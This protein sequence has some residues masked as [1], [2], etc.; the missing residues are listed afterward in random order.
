M[1]RERSYAVCLK[2]DNIP[3]GYVTVGEADSFDLGY[4][5]KKE[6]RRR[7]IMTEAARAVLEELERNGVPYVTATHDVK[8]PK[9][10][11]V[12]KRLGMKYRYSYEEQW[13]PKNIKVVFR[14][15]QLDLDG[16]DG[17]VFTKYRE[18]SPS[19]FAEENL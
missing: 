16:N 1:E 4:G 8:N 19:S 5:L 11:E 3:I 7:G 10:G 18:A 15:Y 6:F 14:M 2:K 13:Q 9:S 12:M 17:R